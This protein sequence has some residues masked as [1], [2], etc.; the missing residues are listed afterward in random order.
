MNS[1][2]REIGDLGLFFL[3]NAAAI[4]VGIL[5]MPRLLAQSVGR[6][7]WLVPFAMLPVLMLALWLF[8]QLG[9]R[10]PTET[11][12]E[13]APRLVG[14]WPAQVLFVSIVGYWVLVTGRMMRD[15]SDVVRLTLLSITPAEVIIAAMLVSAGYLARKGLEPI[16]RAATITFLI[17]MII[18][19]SITMLS[20]L[21]THP[22]MSMRPVL[23]NGAWGVLKE[24]ALGLGLIE[25]ISA[26]LV[27]FPFLSR[28]ATAFRT[29][30]ISL[31]T[32]LAT[33]LIVMLSTLAVFG[34]LEMV[35]IRLPS[36]TAIQTIE[37]PFV[38]IERLS[39]FY[40]ATWIAQMFITVT[41][42]LWLI[43]TGMQRWLTHESHVG[44]IAPA[45]PIIYLIALSPSN[46]EGLD[47]LISAQAIYGLFIH[48][49]LPLILLIMAIIRRP[50]AERPEG[51]E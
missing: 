2:N 23:A 16:A 19:L 18:G 21:G 8:C 7:M 31:A 32:I 48:F 24:G 36:L 15:F 40:V 42:M 20:F 35:H 33:I 49:S 10:F 3:F 44:L 47:K 38:F 43:A 17:T 45:L 5:E 28:P 4:E 25:Q 1:D 41:V 37:Q 50:E 46:V 34:P 39:V 11:V 26:F 12:F 29:G 22:L 13:Y 30:A 14:H 9:T 51:G 27:W 6:D